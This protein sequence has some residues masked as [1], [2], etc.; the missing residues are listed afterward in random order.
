MWIFI[1]DLAGIIIDIGHWILFW[2]KIQVNSMVTFVVCTK[3]EYKDTLVCNSIQRIKKIT[4][5]AVD[6]IVFA[7]NKDG[8]SY[9]YNKAISLIKSG[10]IVFVHD[11]VQIVDMY[12]IDKLID[13]LAKFDI[14]GLAGSK[15]LSL[16]RS[17]ICWH[18]CDRSNWRGFVEHLSK[19]S[20]GATTIMS[21]F[22]PSHGQ[23]VVVDGLFLATRAEVFQST[24]LLRFDEDFSFDFYD[25]SLCVNAYML[26]RSIGVCNIHV[27]HMSHGN[28]ILN[29]SYKIA[30]KLFYTK[31]STKV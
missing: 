26:K 28:G 30:E 4:D 18:N 7:H 25:A 9:C 12:I 22:G 1:A 17:P 16:D 10:Y 14:V 20:N 3:G 11:D 29:E 31:Y 6:E 13:N 21:T 23:C 15:T 27:M 5:M 8:L 24:P 2:D 19:D